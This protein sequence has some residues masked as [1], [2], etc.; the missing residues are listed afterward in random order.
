MTI[1]MKTEVATTTPQQRESLS[2]RAA[3]FVSDHISTPSINRKQYNVFDN[4]QKHTGTID[5]QMHRIFRRAGSS[6]GIDFVNSATFL[7]QSTVGVAVEHFLP[8]PLAL[9]PLIGHHIPTSIPLPVDFHIH[10]PLPGADSGL[11]HAFNNLPF[12]NIPKRVDYDGNRYPILL[13]MLVTAWLTNIPNAYHAIRDRKP[14]KRLWYSLS[15]LLAPTHIPFLFNTFWFELATRAPQK[16]ADKIFAEKTEHI[17]LDK[18]S[19][20]Y[21]APDRSPSRFGIINAYRK[22]TNDFPL[23]G[24]W[25]QERRKRA[26]GYLP[27]HPES[28]GI[29]IQAIEN[30]FNRKKTREWWKEKLADN[31]VETVEDKRFGINHQRE[32]VTHHEDALA[33]NPNRLGR[34]YH[35]AWRRFHDNA[36]ERAEEKLEAIHTAQ[37]FLALTSR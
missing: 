33:A 37:N 34:L 21:V 4:P 17:L 2:H 24:N 19:E 15:T 10:F 25:I 6:V 8:I 16:H 22:L 35:G 28:K 18:G 12:A 23:I 5:R 3:H 27:V 11:A 14:I 26:S 9:L 20:E 1:G 32:R 36:R 13:S 31:A 7:A 29:F 30:R